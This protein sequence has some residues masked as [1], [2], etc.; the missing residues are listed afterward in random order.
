MK[1]DII[2][3]I[4]LLFLALLFLFGGCAEQETSLG[5]ELE[6]GVELAYKYGEITIAD[7]VWYEEDIYTERFPDTTTL[8]GQPEYQRK[9]RAVWS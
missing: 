2:R 9:A 8:L 7:E 4:F 1:G 6:D 5:V 3:N